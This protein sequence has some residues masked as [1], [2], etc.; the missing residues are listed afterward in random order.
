M[1]DRESRVR[2]FT[3]IILAYP[4]VLIL[5]GIGLNLFLFGFGPPVIALPTM[6]IV[7]A[8]IVA[9]T[10]LVFNHTWLMTATE[11]TRLNYNI[12]ASHEEWI[13]N[14]ARKEDVSERGWTEL[15]RHHNAHR[16][17]TE[18]TVYFIILA[19]LLSVVSP[20]VFAA[21]LWFIGFSVARLGYTFGALRGNSGLRGLF[22]SLSLLSLY[23][24]TSYLVLSVLA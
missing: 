22:M 2:R 9:C 4:V 20:S 18:N 11:L 13:Q 7:W 23:G 24:L 16:N 12:Y 15:E 8:L 6:A 14:N 21:Q 19:S 10:L 17:T 5:I 1:T 3:L